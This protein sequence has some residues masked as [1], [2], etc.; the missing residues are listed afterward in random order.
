VFQNANF[1]PFCVAGDKSD[2][3]VAYGNI[4]SALGELG[5]YDEAIEYHKKDLEI[6]QQTGETGPIT[7]QY[8]K[9]LILDRFVLQATRATR[10]LRTATSAALWTR[11]ADTTRRSSTIISIWRSRSRLV[12]LDQPEL[13]ISKSL[14]LAHV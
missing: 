8:F 7:A 5:R 13:S 3:G 9:M 6:A 10:A 2:Q 4:G 1:R 12:R 11:S 14:I